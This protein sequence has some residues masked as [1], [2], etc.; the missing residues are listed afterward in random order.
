MAALAVRV[1]VAL[2][3]ARLR[4]GAA[5][6]AHAD[7]ARLDRTR[8]RPGRV[9]EVGLYGGWRAAEPPG[10]LPDRQPFSL[11]EV[12]RQRDR[13]ATLGDAVVRSRRGGRHISYVLLSP[14][15][16]PHSSG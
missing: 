6:A 3:V 12:P 10:D 16:V 9:V 14:R 4:V 8:L 5:A 13:P 2:S 11:T 7:V 15:R 1:R